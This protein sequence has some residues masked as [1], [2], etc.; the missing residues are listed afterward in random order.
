LSFLASATV[1]AVVATALLCWGLSGLKLI[2]LSHR[3]I[4]ERF[5]APVAVLGPGIHLLMPWPLGVMRSVELGTLH[6]INVGSSQPGSAVQHLG[7]GAIPPA[8]TNH[9]WDTNDPTE[10]EYLVASQS[11]AGTQNF[12]VVDAEIHV[13]YRTGLTDADAMASVY[14][15]MDPATL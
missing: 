11:D 1:P 6:E 9:L 15:A 12:Q 5:G 10:A 14:S 7:A 8:S 13:V 3:G 4:Y 2:D